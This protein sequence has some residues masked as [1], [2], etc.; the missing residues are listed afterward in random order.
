MFMTMP[1]VI[2]QG[3]IGPMVV[4]VTDVIMVII[5]NKIK[6]FPMITFTT[7]IVKFIDVNWM[8]WLQE[9]AITLS[10]CTHF[11]FPAINFPSTHKPSKPSPSSSLSNQTLYAFLYSSTRA[12]C[13]ALHIVRHSITL[14]CGLPSVHQI[15]FWAHFCSPPRVLLA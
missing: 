7:I 9:S 14:I 15:K 4:T 8:L 12:T 6:N 1:A 2:I 5:A 11:P 3:T 13:F 10:L